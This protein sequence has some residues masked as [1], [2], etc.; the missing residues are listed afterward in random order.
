MK[1]ILACA[2]C[3]CINMVKWLAMP[4]EGGTYLCFAARM[5]WQRQLN[6]NAMAL[7]VLFLYLTGMR[8]CRRRCRRHSIRRGIGN[9]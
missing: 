5:R 6:I 8:K 7:M 2:V 9:S 1:R 4:C 3:V